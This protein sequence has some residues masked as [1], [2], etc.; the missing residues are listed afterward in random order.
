MPQRKKPITRRSKVEDES[1]G[2]PTEHHGKHREDD[3]SL[4]GSGGSKGGLNKQAGA[5]TL[6]T[7]QNTGL[8][9]RGSA[10][11]RLRGR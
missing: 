11:P 6:G 1:V 7:M 10:K 2:R 3:E 9:K 4:P 5:G 8:P